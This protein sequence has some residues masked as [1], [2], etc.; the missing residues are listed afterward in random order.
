MPREIYNVNILSQ[1]P[2]ISPEKLKTEHPFD[3]E[4]KNTIISFREE[5]VRILT[6]EDDR[7]L[8]ITGP[9]SIHDMKSAVE[10]AQ[11][12]KVLRDRYKDTL[13]IM[14]RVYFEKP[15]TTLGWRGFIIDPYLD[16]SYNIQDGLKEARNL[17]LEMVETGIPVGTEVLD[18]VIPEYIGDLVS[19]AAIGARTTESQTHREIASGLSMPVGFKN[20]T[21]GDLNKAVNAILSA[22]H[23]HSFIGIDQRGQTCILN[24]QGNRTGHLIVRGG[25]SG[26]NYYEEDIIR[27]ENS[28]TEAGVLPS[29]LIDCSHANSG[30]Q[31]KKQFRVFQAALDL[32]ERGRNSVRGVMLESHLVAGRQDMTDNSFKLKYG[33]SITDSCIGWNETEM[34]LSMA[35]QRLSQRFCG[36]MENV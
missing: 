8:I 16:G 28:L 6:H 31:H 34:L 12:L 7:F 21:D 14:M 29:I 13:N 1:R 4:I 27:A 22:Q 24:T 26:P 3:D 11:K 30:K 25:N 32:R 33:Q 35:A 17:L 10:Y 9:C 5:I 19:W 2:L 36:R 23:S 15:R 20:G 18:P